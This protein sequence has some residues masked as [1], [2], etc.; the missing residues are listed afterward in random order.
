MIMELAFI[1]LFFFSIFSPAFFFIIFWHFWSKDKIRTEKPYKK[2]IEIKKKLKRSLIKE[3]A[4]FGEIRYPIMFLTLSGVVFILITAMFGISVD[5][6]T[7]EVTYYLSPGS[8]WKNPFFDQNGDIAM[9]SER[10]ES[11]PMRQFPDWIYFIMVIGYYISICFLIHIWFDY[12]KWKWEHIPIEKKK[13]EG[14]VDG[15]YGGKIK[16]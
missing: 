3:E 11:N 16:V 14:E 6:R 9:Y 7:G 8:D 12:C 13:R 10:G 2:D 4:P 1:F 15:K 5:T